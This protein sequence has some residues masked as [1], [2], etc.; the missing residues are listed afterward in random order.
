[1]SDQI[2]YLYFCTLGGLAHPRT[3][4]MLRRNGSYT[5]HTYHLSD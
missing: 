4:T 3:Y 1:M 5:Y 2:T